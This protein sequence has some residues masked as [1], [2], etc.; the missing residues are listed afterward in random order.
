[1]ITCHYI[2]GILQNVHQRTF[3]G[4]RPSGNTDGRAL[5]V[6]SN[7]PHCDLDLEIARLGGYARLCA[8]RLAVGTAASTVKA[9]GWAGMKKC[10]AR[11]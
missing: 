8:P 11:V 6:N 1:M 10:V 5:S 9:G 3:S 4:R 2:A 7:L